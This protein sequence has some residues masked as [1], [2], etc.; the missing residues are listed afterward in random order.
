MKDKFD[1]KNTERRSILVIH[2]VKEK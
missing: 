1:L 2:E